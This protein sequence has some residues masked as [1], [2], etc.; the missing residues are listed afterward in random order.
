MRVLVT[1]PDLSARAT[2]AK[3]VALGHEP[4]LLPLTEAV[5]NTNAA[6]RALSE[7]RGAL[8]VTSAEALRALPQQSLATYLHRPIFCVGPATAKAA[9][10]I[11]F[12]NI[13]CGQGTGL[14]LSELVIAKGKRTDPL[15]YL[16]GSPRSPDFEERLTQAG[17]SFRTV[18]VYR[19]V[20]IEHDP[21]AIALQLGEQRPN[22]ILLY[23][24]ETARRFFELVDHATLRTI[25]NVRFLC[26]SAHVAAAVPAHSGEIAIAA[27]PSEKALL[28]LL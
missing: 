25:G 23:S 6:E 22:V 26:M 5:H 12:S 4:L 7:S 16:A 13:S 8:A 1:R 24:H 20:P 18:E 14:D 17:V 3:L 15:T 21:K 9:E 11:G 2:A 28:A 19:M 27:E 10:T